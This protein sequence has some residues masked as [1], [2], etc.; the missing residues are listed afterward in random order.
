M[1]SYRRHKDP[2]IITRSFNINSHG[3]YGVFWGQ[4]MHNYPQEKEPI[5]SNFLYEN[6]CICISSKPKIGKSILAQQMMFSLSS[7]TA[8]LGLN[9]TRPA[10]V[11]YVQTEGDRSET[12]ER[13]TRMQEGI[14]VNWDN[15]YHINLPGVALNTDEG[16][17]MFMAL[18]EQPKV[19]YDV[20]IFDP[21]YTTVLGDMSQQQVATSWTNNVRTIRGHYEAS[22]VVLNH[23]AK[24]VKNKKGE[25]IER[26]PEEIF[27]S[28]FWAAFFN[29]TF[30]FKRIDD[31]HYLS[32]GLQ[33]SGKIVEQLSVRLRQ[34]PLM[35]ELTRETTHDE[36]RELL[37]TPISFKDLEEKLKVS[38]GRVSQVLKR[39]RD[40]GQLE[41]TVKDGIRLYRIKP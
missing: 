21:L 39:F 18:A 24:E 22:V 41:E 34:E 35:F 17:D 3:E 15:A 23:E 14:S 19:K 8:F 6:D 37:A 16:F 28:I 11:L 1:F 26:S 36:V 20:I 2:R 30:Q 33:R 12:I 9:V 32:R 13:M 38:K 27:G 7:G 29:H 40:G 25:I 5:I 4:E 31:V 10:R